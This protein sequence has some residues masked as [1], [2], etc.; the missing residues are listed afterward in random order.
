MCSY[1]NPS[2]SLSL[3]STHCRSTSSTVSWMKGVRK[4]Q[5]FP[6]AAGGYVTFT[7]PSALGSL[8]ALADFLLYMRSNS[9][10]LWC[11]PTLTWNYWTLLSKS[12]PLTS[13][14]LVWESSSPPMMWTSDTSWNRAIK[15]CLSSRD[16]DIQIVHSVSMSENE[17]AFQDM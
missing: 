10:W 13:L 1:K 5:H 4:K 9:S 8:N 12:H 7:C 16:I 15:M 17:I 14:V 3:S 11:C 2:S 6:A